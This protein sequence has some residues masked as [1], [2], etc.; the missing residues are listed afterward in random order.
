MLTKRSLRTNF[1]SQ[2]LPT[3]EPIR[4]RLLYYAIENAIFLTVIVAIFFILNPS[5]E[6]FISMNLHPLLIL[7]ALMSLKYGNYLGILNASL[8][9]VVFIYAYFLLGKDLIIFFAEWS[10]YKFLL[11]FFLTA[12]ILG[13]FKDK[14]DDIIKNL[15]EE[16]FQAQDDLAILKELEK[17]SQIIN[18]ELRKQIVGAEDSIL[19][20]YEVAS[21]LET[22]NSEEL[23]TEIM[24]V[25]ARFLHA[26]T[27]SIYNVDRH[28]RY[29]RL[30]IR[31]GYSGR[32]N[33][34]M[35]IEDHDYLRKV[36]HEQKITKLGADSTEKDPIFS[37][38]I[39]KNRQTIAVLNVEDTDFSMVT[40]Y[41]YN[42]FK[43]IMEWIS[44]S[45]IRALEVEEIKSKD[46][47]FEGTR[48]MKMEQF[49]R[50][51]E[52][53]KRRY[54]KFGLKYG[55]IKLD[56]LNITLEELGIKLNEMIRQVDIAAY[57]PGKDELH[58][59]L[60]ITPEEV[61]VKVKERI[62]GNLAS[63]AGSG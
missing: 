16:L 54:Y 11:M 57:D 8:A 42:L 52:E 22:L 7:V 21:A 26:K 47:Y 17:K 32:M 3:T 18:A 9:S 13:S 48:I 15:R 62:I 37:A 50:R 49:N 31:M 29:L 36:V 19:S 12:V 10:Y 6:E 63:G 39:I 43:I 33:P 14:S 53:E 56:R 35:K 59:L 46:I 25:M 38:P 2:I 44:K 60:P 61:L 34:S 23:Y 28:Q 27:V 41:N 30:K 5:R 4:K 20:L 24:T 58:L 51:L 45:L 40:E 1:A 55:L